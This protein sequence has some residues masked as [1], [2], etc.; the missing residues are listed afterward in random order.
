MNRK[1][2]VALLAACG[3]AAV[4]PVSQAFLD[5][6]ITSVSAS[7]A[8]GLFGG[9]CGNFTLVACGGGTTQC[10]PGKNA[11]ADAEGGWEVDRYDTPQKCCSGSDCGTALIQRGTCSGQ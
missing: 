3:V 6:G 11:A 2:L 8:G 5:S 1:V 10:V 4:A 9:E 7:E